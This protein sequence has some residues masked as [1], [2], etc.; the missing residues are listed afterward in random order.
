MGGM[1]IPMFERRGFILNSIVILLCYAVSCGVVEAAETFR[2]HFHGSD[3]PLGSESSV[4]G[5]VWVHTMA[6]KETLLDIARKYGLGFNEMQD[7]YPDMDPWISKPGLRLSIPTQWIL[8]SSRH[9]EVVINLAELRLYRYFSEQG[10]VKTYPVGIGG[11]TSETPLGSYRVSGRLV[12]PTWHI[13]PTLRKKYKRVTIPP[14]PRNPLGDYWMALSL[15][16]YGIHG[17]NFPWA[18]GRAVSHGCIRLYPEHI[19]ELY[20]EVFVGT[21]VDVVYE[22]VKIGFVRREIFM[23]VHPDVYGKIPD[24]NRYGR[25][26]LVESGAWKYA[27]GEKVEKTLREQSGVPVWVGTI[28]EG[29]GTPIAGK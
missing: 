9:A 23:E 14:G 5:C 27:S 11:K 8:P 17:T 4:V 2:Y 12:Q 6:P 22:P 24:M 13:P 3:E 7:L 20:D 26:R 28:G 16:G 10:W 29:G 1:R 18:I 25:Q 21:R 15:P 19:S